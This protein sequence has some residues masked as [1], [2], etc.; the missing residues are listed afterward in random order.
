MKKITLP[1][2][3]L[4]LFTFI[5][6]ISGCITNTSLVSVSPYTDLKTIKTIIVWPFI[7]GGKID[8][9]GS[10]ATRG[11]EQGFMTKGYRLISYSKMKDVLA[12]EIGFKDGMALDAGLLTNDVRK[13]LKEETSVDAIL[14]GTVTSSFCDITW[15]PPCWMETSFQVIDINTGEIIISGNTSNAGSSIQKATQLMVD[16]ALKKF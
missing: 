1:L 4:L 12:A 9:S 13:R 5:L 15:M 10:I 2:F 7:D 11:F 14:L 6:M 3:A 8:N 16:K